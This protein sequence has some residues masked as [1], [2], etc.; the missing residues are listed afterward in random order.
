VEIRF[1][2]MC[3]T[4]GIAEWHVDCPDDVTESNWP[5]EMSALKIKRVQII[6]H[7]T[8]KPFFV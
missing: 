8:G 3:T 6:S 5:D 1:F 7:E 4:A 2:E